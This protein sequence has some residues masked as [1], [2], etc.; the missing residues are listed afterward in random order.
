[1]HPLFAH[2]IR[3][4]LYVLGWLLAGLP[5]ALVVRAVAPQPAQH[6]HAFAV[7]LSLVYGF[8]VM[9]AWWV[10]RANPLTG[11]RPVAAALTAQFAAALQSSAVWTGIGTGWAVVL[12]RLTGHGPDRAGILAEALLLFATG[13]PLYLISAVVHYLMLA[14]EAS[15][16]AQR[17]VLLTEV[18][19]RE[20]ELRALR[21]QLN[22]HFLFNSLN[23][24]AALVG[25]DPEGARRMC[26]RLGDFLRRTLALGARDAVTLGEELELVDRYLAIE[27]VRFGARLAFDRRIGPGATECV[28]P[29]L[30]L[31]PLVE[32]AVKHGVADRV[33]GG[34]IVVEA[35]REG[36]QLRITVENPLDEEAPSR[37][38]SG[39]GLDNVRRRLDVYGA[40]EARLDAVRDGEMFRVT[41]TMPAVE[42]GGMEARR[43]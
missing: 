5:L 22:P 16:A 21:A 42:A 6:A 40:R 41:L 13:V 32:N 28:V 26:E 33:D 27:Q 18:S 8:V 15:H 36:G 19:A 31:Q 12:V 35:T 14:F 9:S 1:M 30:L 38:G 2:R 29:P 4:A 37:R 43:G 11:G 7:P 10:C 20:A 39:M 34:T 3:L 23:S 24:I 17:R 25:S